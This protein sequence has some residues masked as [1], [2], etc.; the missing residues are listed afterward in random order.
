MKT[1]VAAILCALACARPAHAETHSVSYSDWTVAGQ[2]VTMKFVIPADEAKRLA[3]AGLPLLT[4]KKLAD[5][6]LEH[7]SVDGDGE[8]CAPIDQGYDI[9]LVDPL[10]VGAGRYGFEVFFRCGAGQP[11]ELVLTNT[12]LFER[13]Q[14]H[15]NFARIRAGTG[16]W[17]PQLFTADRTELRV[18]TAAPPPA[19]GIARY[20]SLGFTHVL[21]AFDW[22]CVLLGLLMLVRRKEELGL[23]AGGLA[24]GYVL[25]L[26]PAAA[27]WITSRPSLLEGFVGI[28]VLLL[29]AEIAARG[30]SR[31]RIAVGVAALLL[32]LAAAALFAAGPAA[33]AA[34]LGGA[35][36]AA[37]L[38]PI[39]AALVRRRAFWIAGAAV[40]GFLDGFVLPP[41]LEPLR[42]TAR[43]VL[44]MLVGFDLGALLASGLVA[45]LAVGAF[46]ALRLRGKLAWPVPWLGDATAAVLG[47]CGAFWI[48]SRF[49]G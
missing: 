46:A 15:V 3:G 38:L 21:H 39:S 36:L 42:L 30:A 48:A 43:E 33:A 6:L 31:T 12:V 24:L 25:A 1:V 28:V 11:R 20:L 40:P 14:G 8:S 29:A 17:V 27:G 41:D 2:V 49:F 47:G 32:A 44:P 23:L 26:V 5:Y 45:I 7:T 16:D 9:G 19:A 34:L 13:V 35:V 4:V 10:A 37:S 18:S 22:I